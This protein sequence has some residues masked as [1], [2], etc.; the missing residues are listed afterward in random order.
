MYGYIPDLTGQTCTGA[1]NILVASG[2][3]ASCSDQRGTVSSQ[4]PT[5]GGFLPANNHVYLTMQVT[6]PDVYGF[7]CTGA[8][9]QLHNAALNALC[10]KTGT[11]VNAQSPL[12]GSRVAP[13]TTVTVT[14]AKGSAP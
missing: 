12:P 9:T 10:T 1:A 14:L 3:F 13:G 7:S 6:V 8:T 11:W 5:A 4:S 2:L